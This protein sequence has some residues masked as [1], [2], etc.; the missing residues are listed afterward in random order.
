V[1]GGDVRR[2]PY[3][4]AAGLLRWA[5]D[6]WGFV[7]GRAALGG[8]D[9]RALSTRRF[10]NLVYVMI[11][12]EDK[13]QHDARKKLDRALDRAGGVERPP[14]ADIM[15]MIQMGMVGEP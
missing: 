9:P 6:N 5:S 14:D 10:L 13:A 7:D 15:R 2:A 1:V 8:I 11:L 4:A 3:G 12:E